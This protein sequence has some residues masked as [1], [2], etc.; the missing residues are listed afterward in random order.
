MIDPTINEVKMEMFAD[1]QARGGIL[2][3]PGDYLLLLWRSLLT[4]SNRHLGICE[5]KYRAQEQIV[6]MHRLD[7][8]LIELD[9]ALTTASTEEDRTAISA[10]MRAREK[11]LLPLYT[12]IAH[13]FADLHDRAGRMK[14]KGCI[15]EVLEW[16]T[17]RKFFYWRILRRQ[18]E[19]SIK[20]QL[21]Q[22]SDSQ[23]TYQ[24]AAV[25]VLVSL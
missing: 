5:V 20:D 21:V 10:E 17:S 24:E 19:D 8:Q 9:E 16:R 11:T 13:E 25:K 18:L 7:S 1:K 15:N 23:M 22:A 12:Q 4:Y 14:A 6:T 3:P 2:E